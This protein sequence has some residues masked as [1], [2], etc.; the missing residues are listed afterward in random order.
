MVVVLILGLVPLFLHAQSERWIYQYGGAIEGDDRFSCLLFGAD[1][2]LYASG[3]GETNTNDDFLVVSVT[4]AGD[5]NWTY[6]YNN[7][8]ANSFDRA[9][10]LDYGSDNNIYATGVSVGGGTSVRDLVVFSLANTTGDTN[11]MYRYDAGFSTYDEGH[12]IVYGGDGNVYIAA[13]TGNDYY[14]IL[15]LDDSGAERWFNTYDYT[16]SYDI[17]HSIVYGDDGNIYTAGYSLGTASNMLVV[18]VDTAGGFRWDYEYDGPGNDADSAV[19]I[20]YGDDGNL[21]IAGCSYDATTEYDFTVVSLDTAGNERWVY[22]YN[23]A[24]ANGEDRALDIVYGNDGNLYA[25]G[26]SFGTNTNYDF[27]TISLDTAGNE[28]WV[29]R[30]STFYFSSWNRRDVA[31]ALCYGGNDTIYVAGVTGSLGSDFTVISLTNTGNKVWEY[32]P[33]FSAYDEANSIVHGADGYVYAAGYRFITAYPI[34]DYDAVVISLDA[35][36][37]VASA[38]LDAS[39]ELNCIAIRWTVFSET[40][41]A[42]YILCRTTDDADND[43]TEIKRL[44]AQGNS[45]MQRTYTFRD[46]EVYPGVRYHYKLAI[47]KQNGNKQ[48][49]GPV[50]A[51][52]LPCDPQIQ[53]SPNPFYS[54]TTVFLPGVSENQLMGEPEIN[55]YDLTGRFVKNLSIPNREFPIPSYTWNGR[56][57]GGKAVAAGT[58]FLKLWMGEYSETKKLVKIK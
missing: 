27:V 34:D 30:D 5:T 57:E 48:W 45:P 22:R 10:G 38:Q 9:Y 8:A 55:I 12:D 46:R 52:V 7:A 20:V 23:N 24:S 17:A 43:Y 25:T 40:G 44:P 3:Y 19:V 26:A 47:I 28:L 31:K 36:T 39:A 42:S 2:N 18:S 29:H 58:Y 1:G 32:K 11:W 56:D 50:S 6:L 16:P 54:S 15:S 51:T 35:V 41:N 4:T 13:W 37:G 21:Y 14:T 33:G 53:I 49:C